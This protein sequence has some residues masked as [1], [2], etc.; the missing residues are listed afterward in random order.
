MQSRASCKLPKSPDTHPQLK[1]HPRKSTKK[2]KEKLV[3]KFSP[4]CFLLI[5]KKFF[6]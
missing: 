6:F 3:L 1:Y 5:K 4:K 2:T